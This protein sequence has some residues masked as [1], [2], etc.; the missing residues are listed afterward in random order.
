MCPLGR[1][2]QPKEL[3]F[4][5]PSAWYWTRSSCAPLVPSIETNGLS[6][7]AATLEG[8][9]KALGHKMREERDAARSALFTEGNLKEKV[10]AE[11]LGRVP[12]LASA[13]RELSA[14]H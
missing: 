14:P 3:G 6:V 13:V 5:T 12:T 10:K 2:A 4:S 11:S 1:T 7:D 9:L 8:L